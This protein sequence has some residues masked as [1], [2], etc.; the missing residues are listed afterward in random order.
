MPLYDPYAY[1][2][3]QPPSDSQ[4][5]QTSMYPPSE[6]RQNGEY[7][8]SATHLVGGSDNAYVGRKR[9][10][11]EY[12]AIHASEGGAH[13]HDEKKRASV[14]SNASIGLAYNVDEPR[15]PHRRTASGAGMVY[16]REREEDITLEQQAHDGYSYQ[17]QWPG[18]GRDQHGHEQYP[19][20]P[21]QGHGGQRSRG[22]DGYGQAM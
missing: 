7:A 22:Y 18:Y 6:H 15:T 5:D 9:R 12:D 20:P 10:T 8:N 4:Y 3:A 11:M 19:P 14:Y 16:A 21:P 17:R 1:G 2:N 13:G